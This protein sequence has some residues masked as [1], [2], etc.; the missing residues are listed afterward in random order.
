M[1][2]CLIFPFFEGGSRAGRLFGYYCAPF[3]AGC[4]Q[5]MRRP[6]RMRRG[7]T[8]S[9]A[10]DSVS[11]SCTS[12]P[13]VEPRSLLPSE[14]REYL[15]GDIEVTEDLTKKTSAY[16]LPPMD[17][18]DGCASIVVLPESVTPLLPDEAKSQAGQEGLQFARRDWSQTAHAGISSCWIPTN[19]GTGSRASRLSW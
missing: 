4:A 13:Q 14:L 15:R 19:S 8:W 12:P 3:A 1:Q 2:K 6:V 10:V 9:T 11:K 17:R 7:S 5:R 18:N 16:I